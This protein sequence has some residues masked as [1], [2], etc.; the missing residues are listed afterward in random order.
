MDRRC[1]QDYCQNTLNSTI[2]KETEDWEIK[3][4]KLATMIILVSMISTYLVAYSSIIKLMLDNGS[5]EPAVIR[6]NTYLV[7]GVKL[8]F[9]SFLGAFTMIIVEFSSTVMCLVQLLAMITS[10]MDGF[11]KVKTKFLWFFENVL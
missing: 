6:Q 10:G 11:D 9:L 4:Y 2:L 7:V 8:I 5:F 3:G 1:F